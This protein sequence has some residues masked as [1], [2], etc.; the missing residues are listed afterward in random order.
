MGDHMQSSKIFILSLMLGAMPCIRAEGTVIPEAEQVHV[1]QEVP[2]ISALMFAL[3]KDVEQTCTAPQKITASPEVSMA[4]IAVDLPATPEVSKIPESVPDDARQDQGRS[5]DEP[6]AVAHNV[7]FSVVRPKESAIAEHKIKIC[8]EMRWNKIARL[9]V[10]GAKWSI[11]LFTAYKVLQSFGVIGGATPVHPQVSQ[12]VEGTLDNNEL[13]QRLA[14]LELKVLKQG[15][16]L[17]PSWF[18]LQ[19]FK[20]AGYVLGEHLLAAIAAGTIYRSA[21]QYIHEGILHKGDISWFIGT[22]TNLLSS[23]ELI[24]IVIPMELVMGSALPMGQLGG[25]FEKD[26]SLEQR[27]MLGKYAAMMLPQN[28][29]KKTIFEELRSYAAA[30]G[31]STT[32]D[33]DKQPIVLI[34]SACNSLVAQIESI[35]GFMEY[36]LESFSEAA[37]SEAA[38]SVRYI[39]N[40]TNDFC[41]KIEGVFNNT[42]VDPK[43]RKNQAETVINSFKN[44]IAR[45]LIS[46]SRIEK[47]QNKDS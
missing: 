45:L 35:L 9:G 32:S 7:N 25:I 38:S 29:L 3:P 4:P 22:K 43:V 33:L 8:T 36:K 21:E 19:W 2:E 31:E 14:D 10:E 34:L 13:H 16:V 44:D 5:S 11:G 42:T 30:L 39:Y 40:V 27:A 18:S 47:D 15:A 23:A 46:F 17:S 41:Q 12:K 37:K 28:N 1:K 26:M 6:K 24:P 20:N